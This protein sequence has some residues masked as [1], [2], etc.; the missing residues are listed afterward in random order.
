MK[1]LKKWMWESLFVI[2][3]ALMFSNNTFAQEFKHEIGGAMGT[4]FYLG[5]A[6]KTKFYLH[7]GIVGGAFYRYN[8][9]FH[10]AIKANLFVGT[11]SGNTQDSGNKF[12]FDEQTSFERTFADAGAQIEFNFLPYSDKYEY[13]GTKPFTPYIFAGVGT[14]LATGK[15]IFINA[16]VPLG[17]GFK[18]KLKNRLNVGIEFSMRKLFGDDFDVVDTNAEWDLNAPYGIESSFLKNQDWYSLTMIFLTWD[19][20]LRNDPCCNN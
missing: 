3:F 9:N 8:I 19:F 16:N 14:T 18:Y 5:D 15:N 7:S 1:N 20:G 10:W 2:F 12:P 13:A 17:L 4:S 6:N 11:V